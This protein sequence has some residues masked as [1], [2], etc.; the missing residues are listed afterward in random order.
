MKG[1]CLE[2]ELHEGDT[3]IVDTAL[4]PQDGDLV[5]VIVDGLASVKRFKDTGTDKWLENNHGRYKPEDVYQVGVVTEYNR[6]RR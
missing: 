4:S 2:P 1:L 6:K 5:I 3:L